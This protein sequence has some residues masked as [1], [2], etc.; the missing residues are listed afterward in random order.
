MSEKLP[1][2]PSQDFDT[3]LNYGRLKRGDADFQ[4][5]DLDEEKLRR[6]LK[7][8]PAR[9]AFDALRNVNS[10]TEPSQITNMVARRAI[11]LK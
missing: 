1:L 7:T 10:K 3:L 11:G 6:R 8:D 9:Q 5:M 4:V 2:L